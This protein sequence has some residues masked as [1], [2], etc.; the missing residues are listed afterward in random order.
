MRARVARSALVEPSCWN[1]HEGV[2]PRAAPRARERSVLARLPAAHA[3][4]RQGDGAA[5][6]AA[7]GD[8]ASGS[9]GGAR[10]RCASPLH[11][12]REACAR[13]RSGTAARSAADAVAVPTHSG[14]PAS[15]SSGDLARHQARLVTLSL[16][17]LLL[18]AAPPAACSPAPAAP[19]PCSV[20]THTHLLPAS[21]VHCDPLPL[22]A[23]RA[24]RS[25]S[26]LRLTARCSRWRA[27]ARSPPPR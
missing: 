22:S 2:T 10:G 15:L 24:T 4:A 11:A 6:S 8:V 27:S 25:A 5:P 19:L 16:A 1:G 17:L 12:R 21:L 9:N 13:S 18:R 23:R 26:C 20:H 14:W 3:R 7:H